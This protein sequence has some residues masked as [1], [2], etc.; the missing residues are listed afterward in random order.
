MRVLVTGA[1][2]FLG[3]TLTRRLVDDGAPVRILRRAGS[4]LDLLGT[5][6]D[7]VEHAV[8]D[9][10]APETLT[11]AFEGVTHV[12]HA[13]AYIGFGRRKTRERLWRIN[14]EGTAHVVNAALR[15]GVERL[16]HTSSMAAFGRPGRTEVVIDETTPWQPSRANSAYA[17]SKYAAE[18]EVQ[19]G[20]AEGLDAVLVNP[21]LL[22]GI[23][24]P[25]EN[26]RRIVESV[27]SGA[28]PAIPAGGTNVVD[29]LDVAEGHVRAMARGRPGARYF[30]GSENLSWRVIFETLADAFGVPPPRRPLPP[31]AATAFA[32]VAE[33]VAFLTRSEP[34]FTREMARQ[35]ARFYRY[36]H[37]RAVEE[38]GCT[39]RPF[40]ATARRIAAA[41]ERA[42]QAAGV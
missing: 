21:A 39:F 11:A 14:V 19:R 29:V 7:R 17:R 3:S 16:V 5:A 2:G 6:A 10:T 27:R 35:T 4:R 40:A 1:T 26:T 20:V 15:A 38:L 41:L 34:R 31:A 25:G 30:L 23:G 36:D 28:V 8:G 13:A 33:A 9:V 24:R 37:R 18:M 12:Y 42:P 22:F 32:T